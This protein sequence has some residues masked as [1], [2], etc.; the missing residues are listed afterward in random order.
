MS[1]YHELSKSAYQQPAGYQYGAISPAAPVQG[2]QQPPWASAPGVQQPQQ[3]QP[4]WGTQAA[5]MLADNKY[6]IAG[7]F[8]GSAIPG[9]GTLVGTGVGMG[10]DYMAGRARD[11]T[12]SDFGKAVN[13]II[14]GADMLG[15]LSPGAMYD[16]ARGN[17]AESVAK[18]QPGYR[19]PVTDMASYGANMLQGGMAERQ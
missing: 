1:L 5:G 19:T 18:S 2:A 3:N 12:H 11:N 9:A 14:P 4:G 15:K 8:V 16:W 13:S 10:L 7:G 6:S 17:T